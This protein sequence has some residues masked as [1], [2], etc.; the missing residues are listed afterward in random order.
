MAPATA[1]VEAAAQHAQAVVPGLRVE[2]KLRRCAPAA[3]LLKERRKAELVVVGR[4]VSSRFRPWFTVN[5]ELMR[6]AHGRIVI[7]GEDG[8]VLV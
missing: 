4:S 1:V 2:T 3:A 8:E 5:D 6:R 7:V